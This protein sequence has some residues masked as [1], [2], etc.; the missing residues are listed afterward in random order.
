MASLTF[1]RNSQQLI[2]GSNQIRTWE[3]K[4]GRLIDEWETSSSEIALSP[5]ETVLAA[6]RGGTI[7]LLQLQPKR[8]LGSLR[9]SHYS[10]VSFDFSSDTN[11]I[12][13]SSSDGIRIWQPQLVQLKSNAAKQ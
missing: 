4:T 1:S 11:A 10:G 13:A 3:V 12:I 9:G 2:S 8:L 7:N 6:A 5:N